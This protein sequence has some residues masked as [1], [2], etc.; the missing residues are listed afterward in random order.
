MPVNSNGGNE[1]NFRQNSYSNN[2]LES[3]YE[4]VQTFYERVR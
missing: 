2:E 4:D 1:E 3:N